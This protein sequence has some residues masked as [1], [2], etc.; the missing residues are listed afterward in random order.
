MVITSFFYLL[1]QYVGDTRAEQHEVFRQIKLEKWFWPMGWWKYRP[2][3]LHFL[4]LMKSEHVKPLHERT[5]SVAD[6]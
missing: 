4:W 6:I 2:D 1:L 3:G 5:Q